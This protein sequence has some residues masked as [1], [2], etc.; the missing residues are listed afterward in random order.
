MAALTVLATAGLGG[1]AG[2]AKFTGMSEEEKDKMYQGIVDK[3][4]VGLNAYGEVVDSGYEAFEAIPG[5]N[6]A[7]GFYDNAVD[8]LNNISNKG[9]VSQSGGYYGEDGS[10][11]AGQTFDNT[12]GAG[13]AIDTGIQTVNPADELA[14]VTGILKNI[15][16]DESALEENNGGGGW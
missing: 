12:Y 6:A 3:A 15:W 2:V 1:A 4:M 14:A 13:D 7:T 16:Y 10:W 5:Y 8:W 9:G 11:V